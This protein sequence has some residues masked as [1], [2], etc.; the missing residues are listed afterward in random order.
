MNTECVGTHICSH[1]LP[2]GVLGG[3]DVN[4]FSLHKVPLDPDF[5]CL[6]EGD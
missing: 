1:L 3:K 5:L 2:G 4:A 6:S